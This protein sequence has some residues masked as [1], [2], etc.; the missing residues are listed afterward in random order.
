[1]NSDILLGKNTEYKDQY[2]IIEKLVELGGNNE[3]ERRLYSVRG[4]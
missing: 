1:M 4:H 3:R 2:M